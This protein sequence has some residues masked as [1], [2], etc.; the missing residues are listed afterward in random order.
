MLCQFVKFFCILQ[1]LS[2]SLL[3]S[4]EYGE[5]GIVRDLEKPSRVCHKIELESVANPD[6]IDHGYQVLKARSGNRE[7]RYHKDFKAFKEAVKGGKSSEIAKFFQDK[8]M[9]KL[10]KDEFERTL[11]PYFSSDATIIIQP[12]PLIRAEGSSFAE[13]ILSSMHTDFITHNVARSTLF[14][15]TKTYP[16]LKGLDPTTFR[17]S[18]NFWIPLTEYSESDSWL[19]FLTDSEDKRKE[20]VFTEPEVGPRLYIPDSSSVKIRYTPIKP[21]EAL[22]F[23]SSGAQATAHGAYRKKN[24]KPPRLS[25]EFRAGVWASS[26]TTPPPEAPTVDQDSTPCC[27]CM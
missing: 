13:G 26:C 23:A 18:F 25:M 27:T 6:A 19:G 11:R 9:F 24:G 16:D 3:S 8:T 7:M 10:Y 5:V 2:T 14:S 21:G 15:D 4:P 17:G 12:I 22:V 1:L 20:W